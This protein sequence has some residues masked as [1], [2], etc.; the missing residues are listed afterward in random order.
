M[1]LSIQPWRAQVGSGVWWKMRS[2]STIPLI[3]R[4]DVLSTEGGTFGLGDPSIS[5]FWSPGIVGRQIVGIG[6]A[7]SIPLAT[8]E[9]LG[10]GKWS[11]GISAIAVV[12]PRAWLLSM[13]AFNLWSFAGDADRPDVNQF[14][15][16]YIVLHP[17]GGGWYL[18]SSPIVTANWEAESGDEWLV[19]VGGGGGKVFRLGRRGI[20]LQVQAFYSA[21]HPESLPYPDWT[22]RVQ[23]QFLFVRQ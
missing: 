15:L 20:D 16:Q 1:Q 21:I 5:L 4:P 6:P 23:F 19:P 17:L 22:L 10:T 7:I 12:R 3:Y 2:F 14:L 18:V 13:R 9:S 8:D 11:A